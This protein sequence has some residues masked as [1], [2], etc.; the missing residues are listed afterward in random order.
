M[1]YDSASYVLKPEERRMK[2]N[3]ECRGSEAEPSAHNFYN[4]PVSSSFQYVSECVCVCVCVCFYV[5]VCV[6]KRSYVLW[7]TGELRNR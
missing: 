4:F 1:I 7:I 3:S 6:F 2:A 5:C